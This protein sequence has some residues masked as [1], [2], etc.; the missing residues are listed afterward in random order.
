MNT[1]INILCYKSK[2]LANG[3][4][5]LMIR[6]C[7]DGKKKYITLG[8]SVLPQFWDFEKNKPKRNCPNRLQIEKLILQRGQEYSDQIIEFTTENKHFTVTTLVEKVNK[9]TV[10]RT[11]EQLFLKQIQALKEQWRTGYAMSHLEVYNSLI[12]FNGHLDIY[13]SEY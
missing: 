13:F 12:K 4:H 11:V 1:G 5:P 10:N 9:P 6:I 2:T 3:A 7:K 8:V